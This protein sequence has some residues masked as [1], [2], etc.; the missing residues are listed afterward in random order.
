[1]TLPIR[2]RIAAITDIERRARRFA[3]IDITL[4]HQ[5]L[6]ALAETETSIIESPGLGSP[7]HTTRTR[8][9]NLRYR[10]VVGFENILVFYRHTP[11]EIIVQRV[12]HA[13]QNISRVFPTNGQD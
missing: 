13:H 9:T 11:N 12:L 4:A 7:W 10:R 3:R 1:M 8:M 6:S 5:F 2:Y